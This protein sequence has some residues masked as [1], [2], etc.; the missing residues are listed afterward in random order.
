MVKFFEIQSFD[1]SNMISLPYVPGAAA[2]LGD[3]G[4]GGIWRRVVI[5]DHDSNLMRIYNYEANQEPLAELNIHS[6][7]VRCDGVLLNDSHL[8][9]FSVRCMEIDL[10]LFSR[11]LL[12]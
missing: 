10:A 6:H 3:G 2:W 1:M 5:A 12:N 8:E 4:I 9:S 11:L 7:P